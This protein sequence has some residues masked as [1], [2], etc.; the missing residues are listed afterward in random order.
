M[1]RFIEIHRG[2]SVYLVN[3]DAIRYV[4]RYG[5]FGSVGTIQ[6]DQKWE[7]YFDD[8]FEDVRRKLLD[9]AK[10]EK[11]NLP[12]SPP[13]K[14][15]EEACPP[16]SPEI[17]PPA[18]ACEGNLTCEGFIVPTLDEVKAYAT[19]NGISADIAE[20][21]WLNCNATGWRYKGSAIYDWHSML[22]AWQRARKRFDDKEAKREARID[23]KIDARAA[24]IDAK[25]DAREA[26]REKRMG[27]RRKADNNVEM[28]DE[29]REEVRRDFSF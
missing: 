13:I 18:R 9:A 26:K 6:L 2:S 4:S 20:S 7:I 19:T 25:M 24:H 22:K 11:R 17:P 5:R 12:P 15:K 1:S 16:A 14:S 10:E 29:V 8:P 27:G 3:A 28:T 23:A 21:F